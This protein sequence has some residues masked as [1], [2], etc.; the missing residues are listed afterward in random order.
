MTSFILVEFI[1]VYDST[2][3]L[4]GEKQGGM[5]ELRDEIC[6]SFFAW[7]KEDYIYLWFKSNQAQQRIVVQ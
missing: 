3:R 4:K 6:S 2:G 5:P 1:H 7:E